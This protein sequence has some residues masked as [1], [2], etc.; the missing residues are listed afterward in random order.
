[1]VRDRAPGTSERAG[2]SQHGDYGK[3]YMEQNSKADEAQ[4]Y[5][6]EYKRRE[7]SGKDPGKEMQRTTG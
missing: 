5:K 6:L 1:M 7:P 3:P 2:I 4:P